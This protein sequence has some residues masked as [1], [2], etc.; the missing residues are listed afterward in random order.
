MP[1]YWLQFVDRSGGELIEYKEQNVDGTFVPHCTARNVFMQQVSEKDVFRVPEGH[2]LAGQYLT[3][4]G[5]KLDE[6]IKH[7]PVFSGGT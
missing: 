7:L 4:P 2:P 5:D 1:E 6:A 3:I